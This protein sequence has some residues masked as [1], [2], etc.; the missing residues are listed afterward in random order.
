MQRQESAHT[1][2]ILARPPSPKVSPKEENDETELLINP[3]TYHKCV[4]F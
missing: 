3:G 2:V 4:F 1:D